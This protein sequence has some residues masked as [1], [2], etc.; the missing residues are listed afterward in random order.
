MN[1][2]SNIYKEYNA[3]KNYILTLEK[4][5]IFNR[6]FEIN[7]Y[8]EVYNYIK[9]LDDENIKLYHIDSLEIWKL[10]NFYTDS[11]LY[12]I[13]SQ[14]EILIL[15]NAYNKYRKEKNEIR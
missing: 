11:D 9:Y 14:K 10:F 13:E 8:T 5:E 3:F 1:R 2:E 7:F 15:I 4:K 12:S 6:A